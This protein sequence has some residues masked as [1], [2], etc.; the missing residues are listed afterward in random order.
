MYLLVG[1]LLKFQSE[2]SVGIKRDIASHSSG[3]MEAIPMC[4]H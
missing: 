2:T 3:L 1:M 4:F